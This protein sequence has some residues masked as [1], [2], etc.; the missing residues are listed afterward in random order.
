MNVFISWSGD[1]S[2]GLAKVLDKFLSD[3]FSSL[4][5]WMSEQDLQV[6]TRWSEELNRML[7]SSHFGVL[8]LTPENLNAAWL[9]FEA[10]ALSK[11]VFRSSVVPYR[12]GL[13]S[14][15][16]PPPIAQFQG[17]DADEGGT[18]RLVE[19]LNSTLESPL[20]ETKLRSAFKR[21]WPRLKSQIEVIRASASPV[22]ASAIQRERERVRRF[23]EHITGAWWERIAEEGVGFFQIQMDELHNSVQLVEGRFYN[24]EGVLT[25]R[26][27]SAVA[28]IEEEDSR[29]GIVY[30]R[31]CRHPADRTHNWFHGYGDMWFEGSN[32]LFN[33]GHGTFYDVDRN[34]PEKTLAK[35]VEL[36]RV[37]NADEIATMQNGTDTDHESLVMK[38]V[39]AF[40]GATP[41]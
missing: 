16:V 6:G 7:E 4:N 37:V 17:V 2:K 3:M 27:N 35:P 33:Q 24:E 21:R 20:D 14:E 41:K 31:E 10:G 28:R 1:R 9:L 23:S 8:C 18:W 32:E 22:A 12:L 36:R 40:K 26:W 13:R 38:V 11:I 29:K 15:D 34:D 39:R 5:V 19:I 30:L 25:A